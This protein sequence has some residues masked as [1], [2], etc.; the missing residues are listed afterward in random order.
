[1]QRNIQLDSYKSNMRIM[2]ILAS[3]GCPYN[4][5]FCTVTMMNGRAMRFKDPK[6][7]VKEIDCA[8][9]AIHRPPIKVKDRLDGK[10]KDRRG[11]FFFTDDNFAINRDHA[12]AVCKEIIKYQQETILWVF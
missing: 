12:I 3:R 11:L 2:N 7:V 6:Q 9:K 8:L 4:C 5:E 10:W 1:M